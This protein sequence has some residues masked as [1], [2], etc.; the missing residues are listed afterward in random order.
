MAGCVVDAG[1]GRS[2]S[3]VQF[4]AANAQRKRIAAL[5]PFPRC[6]PKTKTES[7]LQLHPDDAGKVQLKQQAPPL[8]RAHAAALED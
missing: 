4:A 3:L 6:L 8:S 2:S 7:E 1:R 5:G